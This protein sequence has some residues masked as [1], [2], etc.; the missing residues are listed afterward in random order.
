MTSTVAIRL[1]ETLFLFE[2]ENRQLIKKQSLKMSLLGRYSTTLK[3]FLHKVEI[4]R[5]SSIRLV[6]IDDRHLNLTINNRPV[7]FDWIFLRDSCRCSN[8]VDLW[9]QQKLHETVDV[10]FDIGPRTHGVEIFS[11]GSVSI[12]WNKSLINEENFSFHRT[13]FSPK[14]LETYSSRKSME[15]NR[16]ND[17]EKTFWNRNDLEKNDFRFDKIDFLSNE[18]VFLRALNFLDK[19]GLILIENVPN[20]FDVEILTR[21]IGEIRETFYGRSWDVKNVEKATNIAYTAKRLDLHMDLLYLECP[22]GLQLLHCLSNEVRGGESIFSDSFR[23]AIELQRE[24]KS[25]FDVLT[26]FPVT[27]HYRNADRHFHQTRPTIVLNGNSIDHINY[28]P[29]FQAPFEIDTS[30]DDFRLFH[31]ALQRFKTILED[32]SNIVE[33][34]LE[35]NQCVVFNNRRVLHG[36]RAFDPT[37]GKRWLKGCYTDLDYFHD[38][39]RIYREKFSK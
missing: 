31:R 18:K 16:F 14:F 11:D 19:F 25:L 6:S 2:I 37:S 5:F 4:R 34:R 23:A 7:K 9:T 36:R 29:P 8:C 21:R 32:P 3:S 26:R 24:D 15:E 28:S 27:F 38:R 17:R 13:K 39:L 12:D 30:A 1:R 10:P 35:P 22:P 33:F 20:E